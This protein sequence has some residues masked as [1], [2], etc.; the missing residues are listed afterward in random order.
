M[1]KTASNQVP[2]LAI[3]DTKLYVP[4][5]TLSTQDN[6][7][8]I[9]YGNRFRHIDLIVNIILDYLKKT[10]HKLFNTKYTRCSVKQVL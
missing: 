5:V 6:V 8:T 3:T 10:M 2:A 1:A 7:K 4:V 9:V